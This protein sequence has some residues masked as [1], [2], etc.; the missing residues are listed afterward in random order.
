MNLEN[1][2]T[3]V[4]RTCQRTIPFNNTS[5]VRL[6]SKMNVDERL[7]GNC[8]Y[9]TR[10]AAAALEKIPGRV[11]FV[12][13]AL[14]N[15][16]RGSMT[17]DH[18]ALFKETDGG[19]FLV[20]LSL[21]HDGPLFVPAVLDDFPG[22]SAVVRPFINGDT[23]VLTVKP[24]DATTINVEFKI[25]EAPRSHQVT[26]NL[27]YKI[28]GDDPLPADDDRQ[29]AGKSH[30]RYAIRFLT[31]TGFATV[32]YEV[33]RR[34]TTLIYADATHQWERY[35]LD[36]G[37]DAV[38]RTTLDDCVEALGL[39][40]QLVLDHLHETSFIQSRLFSLF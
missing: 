26:H 32:E 12:R 11:R 21:M 30:W 10:R 37:R 17:C 19:A 22:T 13:A 23:S 20:D 4:L 36:A 7:G 6:A 40:S 25:L 16:V 2:I 27:L 39:D 35:C 29:I 3:D 33:K 24:F 9:Q 18:Y 31:D 15:A 34:K 14:L 5:K 28:D 8:I 38:F 1:D